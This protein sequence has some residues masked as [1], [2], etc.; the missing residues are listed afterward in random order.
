M[1]R[2]P[3]VQLADESYLTKAI[4]IDALVGIG[5]QTIEIAV[6]AVAADLASFTGNQHNES[7]AWHREMLEQADID[8]LHD[9]YLAICD[10]RSKKVTTHAN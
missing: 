10:E 9:L 5:F 7:W 3:G 1:S 8:D 4:L 2:R 6:K